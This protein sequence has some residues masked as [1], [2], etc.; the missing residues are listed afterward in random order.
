MEEQ[1]L[2]ARSCL[3]RKSQHNDYLPV[4]NKEEEDEDDDNAV[5]NEEVPAAAASP[6]SHN[7]RSSYCEIPPSLQPLIGIPQDHNRHEEL[8]K[9][10]IQ[11]VLQRYIK[12]QQ[13]QGQEDDNDSK[14]KESKSQIIISK[15][16]PAGEISALSHDNSFRTTPR[17]QDII[18]GRG[19]YQRNHSGNKKLRE[20][21]ESQ[22]KRYDGADRCQKT[23]MTR[24][25][26]HDIHS[27]GGIFLKFRPDWQM[28]CEVSNKEAREK[29]AHMMRDVRPHRLA[30]RA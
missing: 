30:K 14:K 26:V 28:W 2:H 17:A 24:K 25:I 22:L 5:K 15:V 7:E 19:K 27:N 10:L 8:Y 23:D 1:L 4:Q 16:R 20:Y 21:L 3:S 6:H 13:Q 9:R 11:Q 29:I 12:Q 18:F